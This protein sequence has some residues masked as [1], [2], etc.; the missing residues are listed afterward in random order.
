M[1]TKK[2]NCPSRRFFIS[3]LIGISSIV[4]LLIVPFHSGA[5]NN[6][7][8]INPDTTI[9]KGGLYHLDLNSDGTADF[10]ISLSNV[11]TYQSDI[12]TNLHDSCFVSFRMPEDC[13]IIEALELNDTV[14]KTNFNYTFKPDHYRLYFWGLDYCMFSGE[15]GGQTNKYVGLKIVKDGYNYYGWLRIDVASDG[16]WVKLKDYAFGGSGI[17]AGK[18]ISSIDNRTIESQLTIRNYESEISITPKRNLIIAGASLFNS[19]LQNAELKV[20][21]N[22]VRITKSLLP[23]GMYLVRL[24]TSEGI[25][26]IK[27][28]I[29]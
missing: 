28:L 21:G 15:F 4:V 14:A 27:V 8:D 6:Y 2:Q 22:Q 10:Q 13:Y 12:I 23:A 17:L 25:C 11:S 9:L 29:N 16:T 18:V 20:N 5:Q 7:V 24:N 1:K 19:I 3:S 26:T